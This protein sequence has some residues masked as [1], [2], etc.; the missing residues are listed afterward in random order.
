MGS[1]NKVHVLRRAPDGG[2]GS[3]VTG[4]FLIELKWLFSVVVLKFD[5]GSREAYHSH[6]FS[7]LTLWLWGAVR[8]HHRDGTERRFRAGQ[9]KFTGCDTFHKVEG[10]RDTWAI[11]FRGPWRDTWQEARGG[12][13]VTLTHGRKEIDG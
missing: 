5:R 10:L 4:Y 11:S 9:W 6:A 2:Q 13:L 7:A 3:G 12:R 1:R 8:E